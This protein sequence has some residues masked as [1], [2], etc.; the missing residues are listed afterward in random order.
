MPSRNSIGQDDHLLI[1]RERRK[2]GLHRKRGEERESRGAGWGR[3]RGEKEGRKVGEGGKR[4]DRKEEKQETGRDG[5]EGNGRETVQGKK[6]DR[7]RWQGGWKRGKQLSRFNSQAIPESQLPSYP[8]I[9]KEI[10]M[11]L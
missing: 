9:L 4:G 1:S 6:G 5:E 2:V 8:W 11:Y 10:P 7:R 3:V